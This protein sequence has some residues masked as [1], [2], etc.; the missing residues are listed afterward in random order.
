MIERIGPVSAFQ[1]LNMTDDQWGI[2]RDQ[3]T[4]KRN[5]KDGLVAR[6]LACGHPVFISAPKRQGIARPAFNH[7]SGS[8]ISCPWY[9]GQNMK[10]NDAR[11]AQYQ[12]KQASEF[13][14]L[15]CELVGELAALDDRY[16]S[17]DVEDYL[18]PTENAYGRFPD[19]RV[20]WKDVGTFVVEFQMSGTFQ[21]E[22]SARCKHYEREG[23]P[24]L[25]VL[26]GIETALELPQSFVDVIRRHRGNAFVLDT[27]AVAASREQ[28][29]LVLSCYL[30]NA[31]G[32]LDAPKLVRFDSLTV[33]HSKL[34]YHED[35]ITT[36][37]R[38]VINSRRKP[39]FDALEAWQ[40]DRD[41]PLLGF[42]KAQSLL[43]A[44]AFSIVATANGK[45]R[46]YMS[47]HPNVSAAL[48]TYLKIG[49]LSPYA[50]LLTR[51][52]ENTASAAFIKPSVWDHLQ[53]HRSPDQ[54]G[55]H[56]TEWR[57]LREL[58]PE[59]LD[60]VVR[61]ELRYLDTLPR[62]ARVEA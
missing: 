55:E 43:I 18:P 51:L 14:G 53:R 11:A 41:E 47:K 15:M 54:I 28:R 13:H 45:P 44:G 27:A 25:W 56:S 34:V 2:I 12:G 58:L 22:I 36:L 35:R 31:Q 26:F 46:N 29:T 30:R 39:W 21:T 61:E 16:V 24:L 20:T 42:D 32:G 10:P 49:H 33:P 1:L 62:W 52:I 48:N 5:G 23:I 19:I 6:C 59:A 7:Y 9:Q 4:D 17:H 40:E 57:L 37:Q 8:D 38:E 60:P 3:I 50:D